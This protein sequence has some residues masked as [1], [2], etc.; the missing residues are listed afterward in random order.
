MAGAYNDA[1]SRR[2]AY[3]A[4]G[5]VVVLVRNAGATTLVSAGDVSNMNNENGLS[6]Y[7]VNDESGEQFFPTWLF[8]ESRELDG[9]YLGFTASAGWTFEESASSGDTTNGTDGTW[10]TI[11]SPAVREAS[12]ASDHY[13]DNIKSLAIPT[14]IGF[15]FAFS[16][17]GNDNAKLRRIHLYGIISPSETPDR[18]LF[19][20]T[21]NADAVFTKVLDFGDLPRG[22]T[23]TRTFKIKNNSSSLTINTIQITAEDL[24]LNAGDWYEFGD[25]GI[26]FQA[27]FAAGNLGQGDTKL[28]Y[29]KQVIPGAETLGVQVGRIKVSHASLT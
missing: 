4:D 24:Y 20:D 3:D 21:L 25:D 27:T 28:I 9:H 14:E 5:T 6:F 1:P 26:A 12:T 11:D 13:R 18:I 10:T 17:D 2:M 7:Q 22:Q 23:Q 29:L 16:D 8:P 19:L 15:R